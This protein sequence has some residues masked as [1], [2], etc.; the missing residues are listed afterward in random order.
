MTPTTKA[1][2]S[3]VATI[4][5]FVVLV[6]GCG[7]AAKSAAPAA[8]VTT[9]ATVTATVAGPVV[10]VTKTEAGPVV[11]ST[12]T[13]RATVTAKPKPHH[14]SG[15]IPGDGTFRVGREVRPG[16]Y[17]SKPDPL[18]SGDCYWARL[19]SAS[20]NDII[21]NHLGAGP[22]FV[23]IHSTD[24]YFQTVGCATWKRV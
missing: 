21:D 2:L 20:E 11:W 22:T 1:L 10:T 4:A 6:A 3:V 24:R 12:K 8:T 7:G 23:T 9:T 18:G 15:S 19:S 16:T 14:P 5:A 17:K 13:V